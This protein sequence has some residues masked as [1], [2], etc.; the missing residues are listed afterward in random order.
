MESIVGNLAGSVWHYLSQNG[1]SGF[2][3]MKTALFKN[4]DDT[5][6][7][8]EKLGMAIGWLLKE[9][10]INIIESGTGKGYRM[11]ISLKEA[12]VQQS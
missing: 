6:M 10:K 4:D 5:S 7:T 1:P 9:G 8:S 2:K 12:P 11:T 3:K